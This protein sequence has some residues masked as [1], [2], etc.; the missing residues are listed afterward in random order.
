MVKFKTPL[1]RTVSYGNGK[2]SNIKIYICS[3]GNGEIVYKTNPIG[4]SYKAKLRR[5]L[6]GLSFKTGGMRF[7]LI[8]NFGVM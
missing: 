4:K 3:I 5:D 2:S 6:D 7:W 8:K 1:S